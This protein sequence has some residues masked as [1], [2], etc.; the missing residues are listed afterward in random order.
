MLKRVIIFFISACS[1]V[2]A[3]VKIGY[4]DSNEI[5]SSF[6]EWRQVQVYLQK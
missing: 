1:F 3:E 4:V 6:E 2:L 5:M